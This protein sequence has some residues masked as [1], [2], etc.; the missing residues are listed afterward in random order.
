MRQEGR[1]GWPYFSCLVTRR[2]AYSAICDTLGE[3]KPRRPLDPALGKTVLGRPF[4][5]A[6]IADSATL[7]IERG[8]NV[9]VHMALECER[10]R[11][12]DRQG[13]AVWTIRGLDAH[14]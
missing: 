6:F 7:L 5:V 8:T 3:R 2:L 12:A 13:E 14:P 9:T 11:G 4:L 1:R 10:E